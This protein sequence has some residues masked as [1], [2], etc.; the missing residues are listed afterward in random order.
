MSTMKRLHAILLLLFL[1]AGTSTISAQKEL[2]EGSVTIGITELESSDQQA[3]AMLPMFKSST[4]KF[5]FNDAKSLMTMNMMNGMMN[6]RVLLDNKSKATTMLMD[7]M[8]QK[9][10]STISAEEAKKAQE[11]NKNAMPQDL[12]IDYKVTYDRKDTKDI[13]GHKCFKA[14]IKITPKKD[15][16]KK[17]ME[18]V[19]LKISAYVT[20]KIKF[21]KSMVESFEESMGKGSFKMTE[22]P[23]EFSLS[24][25]DGKNNAKITLAATEIKNELDKSV[26]EL[27]TTG[28]EE[29]SMEEMMKG[30]MGGF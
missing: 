18:K 13:L 7:M 28:Y 6:M 1:V 30:G 9:T 8:G 3:A 22:F 12:D 25:D 14:V 21:P 24:F 27:D 26:F 15:E 5:D 11:E 10:M 23:L 2:K 4:M 17:Q 29:K 20:D 19:D 16:D